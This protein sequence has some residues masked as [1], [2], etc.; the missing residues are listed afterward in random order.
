[1][2]SLSHIAWSARRAIVLL[3]IILLAVSTFGVDSAAAQP[4]PLPPHQFFGDAESGSGARIDG[5]LAP[6]GTVVTAIN[7]S[8]VT[9]GST[10]IQSGLWLIQVDPADATSVT[11]LLDCLVASSPQSVQSGALTAI[12]LAASTSG[13]VGGIPAAFYRSAFLPFPCPFP[14]PFAFPFPFPPPLPG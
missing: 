12:A 1:M 3:A 7:E 6:D 11:F 14:F 9:V 2:E 4:P 8:G 5:L 10:T 13:S